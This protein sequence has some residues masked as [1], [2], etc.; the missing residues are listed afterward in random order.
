MKKN[1]WSLEGIIAILFL[2]FAFS[3][4]GASGYKEQCLQISK[5]YLADEPLNADS[6]LAFSSCIHYG[7]FDTKI[8]NPELLANRLLRDA[9]SEGNW[10]AKIN[11]AMAHI[12]GWLGFE[13]DFYR[14]VNL[15]REAIALGEKQNL[16]KSQLNLAKFN[17]IDAAMQ[18]G[19]GD[20][21]HSMRDREL[22]G[23]AFVYFNDT[24]N[25]IS[26]GKIP[27]L[28]NLGIFSRICAR[29]AFD[30][31][32][33]KT[34]QKYNWDKNTSEFWQSTGERCLDSMGITDDGIR[35][36]I[37]LLD[38]RWSSYIP[39]SS[40][41]KF[42]DRVENARA[43]GIEENIYR[44]TTSKD[45]NINQ[46]YALLT[47]THF[48]GNLIQK[49]LKRAFELSLE[50]FEKSPSARSLNQTIYLSLMVASEKETSVGDKGLLQLTERI[51][52][53]IEGADVGLKA[54]LLF[55]RAFLKS[56]PRMRA[57]KNGAA[58]FP[59]ID[60]LTISFIDAGSAEVAG[61]NIEYND[62]WLR[63][64]IVAA[65]SEPEI[66]EKRGLWPK[67]IKAAKGND[68]AT[69]FVLE[70]RQFW[71]EKKSFN[72]EEWLETQLILDSKESIPFLN[73]HYLFIAEL[74]GGPLE[75]YLTHLALSNLCLAKCEDLSQRQ[76]SAA[77]IADFTENNSEK[78]VAE[79]NKFTLEIEKYIG[80]PAGL[81]LLEDEN[82]PYRPIIEK[83]RK[84]ALLIAVENYQ[85]FQNLKT[86]VNDAEALAK[87]LEEKYQFSVEIQ[88]NGARREI[89]QA[90]KKYENSLDEED[91]FILFFA[92]HGRE[93]NGVN[94]WLPRD[95]KKNE[96]FDWLDEDDI[97][98]ALKNMS[99]RSALIIAD[100][101]FSG[102]LLRGVTP[103]NE[104][105]GSNIAF[106]ILRENKS[107]VAITSGGVEEVLDGGFNNHSV[108]MEAVL[109]NLEQANQTF[110][111][112]KLHSDVQTKVISRAVAL[113]GKQTPQY[114]G[115]L[116]A[117]HE[118]GD[119][120][121]EPITE[122]K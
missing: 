90:I 111:A 32:I 16:E 42:F 13:Y 113:G 106:D 40:A 56:F 84:I 60:D 112:R 29:Y 73:T 109:E 115:L 69:K 79:L 4:A 114:D 26:E 47:D 33:R 49:D 50:W 76:A 12:N 83:G 78:L 64:F 97:K 51:D 117:G 45:E 19:Y 18:A 98:R 104:S 7:H 5:K 24:L 103:A 72:S 91:N 9:S 95:A 120:V 14:G 67:L 53:F 41:K 89:L 59:K 80:S 66:V 54:S 118:G 81:Q 93:I 37:Q 27:E 21:Q 43:K 39:N 22:M 17:F 11:L 20:D 1:R 68:F 28:S 101:C 88:K 34:I 55:S 74:E 3:E 121:F 48:R 46:V 99:A 77:T 96:E 86:P 6:K 105:R 15:Y 100:A 119:F 8:K 61:G 31:E 116:K 65:M 2:V 35:Q 30:G 107:R 38:E 102:S 85:N 23:T 94:Y 70:G 82:S 75:T 57:L 58:E 52:D 92:G 10:N 25:D 36:F 108:F 122:K 63:I 62:R 44:T 87:V 110:S 71:E